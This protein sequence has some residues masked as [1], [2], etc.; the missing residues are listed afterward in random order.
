M[1]V[2]TRLGAA[3]GLIR[4]ASTI[5]RGITTNNGSQTSPTPKKSRQLNVGKGDEEG[6]VKSGDELTKVSSG[7]GEQ[8]E[9]LLSLPGDVVV[10]EIKC[11]SSKRNRSP[12][13]ADVFLLKEKRVALA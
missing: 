1:V 3:N 13:V 10:G 4:S 9:L 2:V 8:R 5:K 11:R 12:Y 6:E 7:N